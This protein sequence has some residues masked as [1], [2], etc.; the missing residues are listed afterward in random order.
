V[1]GVARTIALL[2]LLALAGCG[3]GRAPVANGPPTIG[4]RHRAPSA[5]TGVVTRTGLV[6]GGVLISQGLPTYSS[7]TVVYPVSDM[8]DSAYNSYRC[9]PTCAGIIN[10]SSVPSAE[11][12]NDIVTWYADGN[13]FFAQAP[14]LGDPNFNLPGSF[15]IDGCTSSCT[16]TPPTSG[17]TTLKSVTHDVYG[18][19]Q[20]A[21][22]LSAYVWLRMNV[23]AGSSNNRS[24][25]TDAAWH[26]D[27]VS[28]SSSCTTAG[29]AIDSWLFLGDSITNNSML[30]GPTP[31]DNYMQEVHAGNS[32]FYPSAVNGGI[33]FYTAALFRA[34]DSSTGKPY[35]EDFLNAF[36][37][38]HF[39][40]LNLGS[41]DIG[42]HCSS[43][44]CSYTA[45]YISGMKKLVQ[46]VIN[47]GRVPVV[48]TIP[49]APTRCS[50]V[51]N[52][53]NPA[54]SGTAN[55]AIEHSLYTT[56]PQIIHGPDLWNYFRSNPSLI[57]T[58][59]CPHPTATGQDDYR[60]LWA[61]TM[62]SAVYG[63]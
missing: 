58:S 45:T 59:N 57:N 20:Y 1:G 14:D 36:P 22:N 43:F 26:M 29:A 35:I 54:T 3:G 23:T 38:A 50:A 34:T 62:E 11:R 7:G 47:A 61:T 46:D 31:P 37:N 13:D 18:A 6:T 40:T 42:N 9:T 30:Y 24:G 27:V 17:W 5:P 48:P 25:N 49:W 12:T 16:G 21:L 33:S 4:H 44:P 52:A 56:Y 15:T 39:V 19:G 2:A 8:V 10:L 51:A 63:R 60:Q 55:Y 28:C 41:N 32:S 53:D